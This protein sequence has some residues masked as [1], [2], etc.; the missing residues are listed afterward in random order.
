LW[1][2]SHPNGS[3]PPLSRKQKRR[4]AR[5]AAESAKRR[6]A[7]DRDGARH[8]HL[9]LDRDPG[10]GQARLV[11]KAPVF[12]DDWQNELATAAANT[13]FGTMR[14]EPSV[15]RAVELARHAMTVASAL[16]EDFLTRLPEGA[17]A[18]KAGC[19]HCCYQAVHVT[20][21]EALTIVDHLQRRLSRAELASLAAR[22]SEACERTRGLA[23]L[24]R[25]TSDHPCPFLEAGQC[26]IYEVRP[27]ACRG[28]NS[29]DAGGCAKILRDP[30]AR[31]EFLTNPRA[32]YSFAEPIRAC[33]A[34][35]AGLQLGL[36]EVYQ[37]DMHPLEL[38]AAVDLLLAGS[39]SLPA[40]W[41]SGQRAF[42]PARAT[43]ATNDPRMTTLSGLVS[44]DP[45]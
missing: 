24:D 25:M 15:A 22:V 41:I 13:A 6:A 27:L 34:I 32:G 8:G 19:A 10:S 36:S 39:Q 20:P 1:L 33:L 29:L 31:A 26:A 21:P 37:L 30:V 2:G 11:L 14:E 17:V 28:M 35:S 38:A 42:A 16:S 12:Q 45:S 4:T 3:V 40:H 5:A 18:C 44:S 9:Q 43:E 7:P 23:P